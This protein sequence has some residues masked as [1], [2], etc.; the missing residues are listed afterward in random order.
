MFVGVWMCDRM[1]ESGEGMK[2]EGI[3]IRAWG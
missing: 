2:E 1:T 3:V